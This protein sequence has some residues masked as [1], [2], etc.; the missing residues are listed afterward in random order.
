M[1]NI[2]QGEYFNAFSSLNSQN[3]RVTL[4]EEHVSTNILSDISITRTDILSALDELDPQSSTAYENIPARIFKECKESLNVRLY[5]YSG[6]G[7]SKMVKC[8][9]I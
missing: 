2:L 6:N 1:A 8:Q 4:S 5:I 9:I 3:L 7:A